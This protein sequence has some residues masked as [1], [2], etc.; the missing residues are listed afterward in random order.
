[1]NH[2][3]LIFAVSSE[4]S[5]P[6]TLEPTTSVISST[7]KEL[8][9]QL[10]THDGGSLASLPRSHFF[11]LTTLFN[12]GSIS[13][14]RMSSSGIELLGEPLGP[15]PTSAS[16]PPPPPSLSFLVLI[17]SILASGR[18]DVFWMAISNVE[19]CFFNSAS[20]SLKAMVIP[21][22]Q[23]EPI[24][25]QEVRSLERATIATSSS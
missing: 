23:S 5:A 13:F 8:L 24:Q 6:I 21:R 15:F 3:K 9:A 10:H 25:P 4:F 7:S 16:S 18:P 1:M 17:L 20:D 19:I 2:L 22:R 14:A 12:V 11:M